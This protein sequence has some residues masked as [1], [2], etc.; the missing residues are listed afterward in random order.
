MPLSWEEI[1]SV[2][3]RRRSFDTDVK[4]RMIEVRDRYNGDYVIPLPDS[5]G[6]PVLPMVMPNLIAD[7]I[8]TL[9]LRAAAV[10]PMIACPALDQDKLTGVR[11][12]AMAED[13]ERALYGAWHFSHMTLLRRRAYRQV[14]GYGD[15]AFIVVPDFKSGRARIETRDALT[16]YP[17]EREADDIRRP[18]NCGFV[19]GR[20]AAWILSTLA[21][22]LD[23]KLLDRLRAA[24]TNDEMWEMVEWVDDEHVVIGLLGQRNV[25]TEDSRR[26]PDH[27][28]LHQELFRFPN[29]A[30][31]C[32]AVVGRRVTMDRIAGQMD[33]M[34]PTYDLAN[35]IMALEVDAM[36]RSVYP[37]RYVIGVDSREPQIVGQWHDG[38]TG[39]INRLSNV[40]GIGALQNQPNQMTTMITDRLESAIRQSAGVNALASGLNPGSLRTGRALDSYAGFSIEP[41]LMELNDI[42]ARCLTMVNEC[43]VGVEKGYFGGTEI[44]SYSGDPTDQG[45][46][47]Y[48]P[49][50]LYET[51]LNVVTYPLPGADINNMTLAAGQMKGAKIGSALDV[52][53]M[54]PAIRNPKRSLREVALDDMDAALMQGLQQQV[55][56]GG[57]PLTV[58][59]RIKELIRTGAPLEIAINTADEEFKEMQAS[60]VEPGTP[61]AMPGMVP[62]APT[63][64]QTLVQEPV[65]QM[66][67]GPD[68]RGFRELINALQATAPQSAG[69]DV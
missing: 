31:Y 36:E 61:E 65:Q 39:I 56:S 8:E 33:A 19:Y 46:L 44:I 3:E 67:A 15:M 41:R 27:R 69:G 63:G 10:D 64:P 60:V 21:D 13:R 17:D 38:R 49:A 18:S 35:K 25:T 48:D 43:V 9:A 58:V 7:G 14:G 20:T 6:E 12:I 40:S 30:G 37:D 11:S 59:A 32:T 24:R 50:K 62:G 68:Q 1:R 52:A 55:S 28:G 47:T 23:G 45:V 51:E 54:H 26:Y 29:R 57:I 22:R 2:M 53:T 5:K 42:M 34:L 66:G 16:S 4:R